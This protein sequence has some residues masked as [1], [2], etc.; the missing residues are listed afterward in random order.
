MISSIKE[1]VEYILSNKKWWLAPTLIMLF[2]LGL[3]L[4]AGSNA[5]VMP[6]IYSLF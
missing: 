6:F 3:L 1:I 4:I 2:L 5:A